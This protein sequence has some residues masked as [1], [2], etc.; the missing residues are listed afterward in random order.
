MS[1]RPVAVYPGVI[2]YHVDHQNEDKE[3][4]EYVHFTKNLK[5]DSVLHIRLK[6]FF[7]TIN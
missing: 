7:F 1:D 3:Q 6:L 4:V 2:P 5:E